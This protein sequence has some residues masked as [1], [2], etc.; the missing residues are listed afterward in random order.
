MFNALRRRLPAHFADQLSYYKTSLKKRTNTRISNGRWTRRGPN[1]NRQARRPETTVLVLR[2]ATM[3]IHQIDGHIQR[4]VLT[5]RCG[6]SPD[7]RPGQF[8]CWWCCCF[9]EGLKDRRSS[10]CLQKGRMSSRCSVSSS[11]V[12]TTP[13]ATSSLSSLI[14]GWKTKFERNF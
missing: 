14:I 3:T 2:R 4:P 10:H 1:D 5:F 11:I 13:C 7:Q 12:N 6:H 8:P 9:P